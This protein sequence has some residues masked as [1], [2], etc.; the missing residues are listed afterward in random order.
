MA[1]LKSS[2]RTQ[3]LHYKMGEIL[4]DLVISE[5]QDRW[6][7]GIKNEDEHDYNDYVLLGWVASAALIARDELDMRTTITQ[8]VASTSTAPY[9]AYGIAMQAADFFSC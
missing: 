2:Q 6:E 9:A 4:R 7:A 8:P 5:Q 3:D 1:E